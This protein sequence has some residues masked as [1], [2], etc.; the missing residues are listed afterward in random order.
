MGCGRVLGSSRLLGRAR[1]VDLTIRGGSGRLALAPV[2]I[3]G[4]LRL[5]AGLLA[6]GRTA[7]GWAAGGSRRRFLGFDRKDV[8]DLGK[9]GTHPSDGR[10]ELGRQLRGQGLGN[11]PPA[12]GRKRERVEHRGPALL[13]RLCGQRRRRRFHELVGEVAGDR[14]PGLRGPRAQPERAHHASCPERVR[15][16]GQPGGLLLLEAGGERLPQLG[17]QRP[18]LLVTTGIARRIDDGAQVSEVELVDG[19]DGGLGPIA[20]DG[21]RGTLAEVLG[22]P[23]ELI[24]LDLGLTLGP[25]RLVLLLDR[26]AHRRD[27]PLE[28]LLGDRS[29]LGGDGL[30]QGGAV[31]LPGPEALG[32]RLGLDRRGSRPL[33]PLVACV[34][35]SSGR[36]PAITVGPPTLA[37]AAFPAPGTLATRAAVAA[38]A[39]LGPLTPVP[40]V[41]AAALGAAVVA[42]LPQQRACDQ[43]SIAARGV[44]LQPLRLTPRRPRRKDRH[45]AH[46]VEVAVDLGPQH[47]THL[48]SG[49]GQR[50]VQRAPRFAGAGCA[51]RPGAVIPGAGE[52]DVDPAGHRQST[53][54]QRVHGNISVAATH[55]ARATAFP[56]PPAASRRRRR[57]G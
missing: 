32:L 1:V 15:Q 11:H 28:Q 37:L 4:R 19:G 56:P 53:L 12:D 35:A 40:A 3:G 10:A 45:D 14:C 24:R 43:R 17:G 31:D 42:A 27:A 25:Q 23:Q 50:A 51:P 49:R 30:E 41:A 22:D 20:P 7:P 21:R 36:A 8:G 38:P 9:P 34:L 48:C 55:P 2:A 54:A 13:A 47:V 29:L 52:L 16:I 18:G 39:P 46:L 5:G 44:E 57:R 6:P 33:G 26:L